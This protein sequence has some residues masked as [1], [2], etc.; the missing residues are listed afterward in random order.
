MWIWIFHAQENHLHSAATTNCCCDT[1]Q[2]FQIMKQWNF[3]S[4]HLS[5]C[6]WKIFLEFWSSLKISQ[7]KST[8]L[9]NYQGILYPKPRHCI[10]HDCRFLT[11]TCRETHQGDKKMN[12]ERT[13]C[14]QCRIMGYWR[15]K[16]LQSV[17]NDKI[18]SSVTVVHCC[19]FFE[20][21]AQT[22]T[23]WSHKV[24]PTSVHVAI[25]VG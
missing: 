21:D 15:W 17:E 11:P 19:F 3:V 4:S 1:F 20:K 2:C 16:G 8:F 25:E 14:M 10:L 24:A 6:A 23:D 5:C 22:A 12:D 7:K 13:P 18:L 9:Q